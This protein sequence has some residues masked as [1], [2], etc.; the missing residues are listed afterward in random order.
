[1]WDSGARITAAS[2]GC[3]VAQSDPIVGDTAVCPLPASV[4]ANLGDHDDSYWGWDGPDVIDAGAGNDNP[5]YGEGGDDV[6]HGGVGGD[7]LIGQYGDDTLDG[8]PGDDDLEGVP[9]GHEDETATTGS[10]TYVGGGGGD[11]VTYEERS[12]NL[13]LSPDGVAD[14]GAAGEHDNI[15]T[16]VSAIVGGHGSDRL[17]GNAYRNVF[18]GGEGDDELA[19]AGGDDQLGGGPG[20]DRLSGGDGQDVLGGDDGDDTLDGGAGVDRLFGDDVTACLAYSCASGQDTIEARDGERERIDCGPGTDAVVAD[21]TD[22]IYDDVD[23]SNQCERV[24]RAGGGGAAPAFRMMAAA[25]S[26]RI[27]VRVAVP[28]PGVVSVRAVSGRLR[29]GSASR[30]AATSGEVKLRLR[31]SRAARRALA[32][33]HRL[34]VVVRVGFRPASGVRPADRLRTVVLR[35]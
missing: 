30:R 23:L 12:E 16:D 10:D 8:G 18:A 20:S 25:A 35:R 27:A 32:R 28:G 15:A 34:R 19:G 24:D 9:G 22:V 26:G 2:G 7:V 3:V 4:A 31:P 11:T 14:D 6:I 29:V 5:I 13:S 21:A 33:R 1:V 17:T